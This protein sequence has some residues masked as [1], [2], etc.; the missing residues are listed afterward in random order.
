VIGVWLVSVAKKSQRAK[1]T[2]REDFPLLPPLPPPVD[3]E[4]QFN[5]PKAYPL[6]KEPAPFA[7]LPSSN[8]AP[9]QPKKIEKII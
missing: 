3:K 4:I 8:T 7:V 1:A 2:K 6:L 9:E 5:Q